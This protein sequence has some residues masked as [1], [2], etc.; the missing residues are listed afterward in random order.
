MRNLLLIVIVLSLT[1]CKKE[2]LLDKAPSMIGTWVHYSAPNTFHIIIV[3]EDG[4][5]RLEW[6]NEG[7]LYKDTPYRDWYYKDN[8]MYFGKVALNGELY[9]II[10]YPKTAGSTFENNFDVIPAGSRYCILENV[11]YVEL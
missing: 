6:Y 8:T 1:G 4:T 2:L 5:G 11:Y 9:D 3:K 10:E 7:G